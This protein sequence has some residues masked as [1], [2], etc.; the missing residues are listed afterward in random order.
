MQPYLFPYLGYFQLIHAVDKFVLLDDVNFINKGW[1][2]RNR[3]LVNGKE[4]TF[5]VSL[6]DAS[7]NKLI[8][9]ID[10]VSDDKW[11]GKFLKTVEM[12]Y[13][14]APFAADVYPK[15]ER[16]INSEFRKISEVIAYSLDVVMEYIGIE[17]ELVRTS[18]V[19]DRTHLKGEQRILAICE[20]EKAS[21]YINLIGGKE[22]Y[23]Q[24]TFKAAGIELR[25]LRSSLPE[26]DQKV[27][28]FMP[29]LSIIDIMMFNSPLKIR[30]MLDKYTLE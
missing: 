27:P 23:S 25:F 18:S 20:A 9:D 13:K 7:Q 1:I 19:Y 28:T 17:T 10:I 6:V 22:L 15:I 8:K 30:E 24:D 2:N 21:R 12:S 4:Y 16:V 5:T 3:I 11:K 26:Y 14:K 29:G